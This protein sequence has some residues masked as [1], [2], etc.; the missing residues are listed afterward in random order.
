LS[1]TPRITIG[2]PVFRGETLVADALRSVEAQTFR[3]FKVIISVDGG[4]KRSAAACRPFERDPRFRVVVQNE[5]L[6]WAGNINWLT[7]QADTEFF[8]YLAQDDKVDPVAY[9]T[10]LAHA[11]R[12]PEALVVYPDIQWFGARDWIQSEPEPTDSPVEK[13]IASLACCPWIAFVGL[14]RT[15]IMKMTGDLR[16][17]QSQSAF[18]DVIWV[19]KARRLGA[20]HRVARPLHMKRL[21]DGMVTMSKRKWT[22][23]FRRRIWIDAWT[24]MLAAALDAA[25]NSGDVRRMLAVTLKRLAVSA[26]DL[27][28]FFDLV[29][30][31]VMER[32]RLVADFI[33]HLQQQG[34]IDLPARL[35]ESWAT[36]RQWGLKECGLELGIGGFLRLAYQQ[37]RKLIAATT[38][39]RRL[40]SGGESDR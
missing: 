4:D 35:G 31:H 40:V 27:D 2:I 36:I 34:T 22:P 15:E 25:E 19:M 21:H 3:D 16:V 23:D 29:P 30:L 24:R 11:D 26:P 9:E 32:R 14:R 13:T 33:A 6:G 12:H 20:I 37:P 8:V 5:Q 7:H 10:L 38:L 28:W 17:D 18:E 1:Q 39:G